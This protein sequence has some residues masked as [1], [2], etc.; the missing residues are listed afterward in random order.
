MKRKSLETTICSLQD[1]ETTIKL[2]KGKYSDKETQVEANESSL[3]KGE[4]YVTIWWV[5]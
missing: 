2:L 3:F 4:F 1:L 5:R